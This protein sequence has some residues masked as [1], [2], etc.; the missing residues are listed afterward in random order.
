MNKHCE[1]I[2]DMQVNESD[3]IWVTVLLPL[4]DGSQWGIARPERRGEERR[5]VWVGPWTPIKYEVCNTLLTIASP[6][7]IV[8]VPVYEAEQY[9][10][11]GA[12]EYHPAAW[13]QCLLCAVGHVRW[14][15]VT[16]RLI[17]VQPW[18]EL[19]RCEGGTSEGLR[20]ACLVHYHNTPRHILHCKL[21]YRE[22]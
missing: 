10:K 2:V 17:V 3:V 5:G 11:P 6:K 19:E 12:T 16:L 14:K 4:I 20:N 13:I 1:F 9:I 15:Y 22:G 7:C 8:H 18:M 21:C